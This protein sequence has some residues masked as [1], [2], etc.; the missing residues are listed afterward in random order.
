MTTVSLAVLRVSFLAAFRSHPLRAGTCLALLLSAVAPSLVAFAFAGADQLAVEGALGTATLAGPLLALF[1]GVAF[2]TGDRP[3]EG[4]EPLLRV[5]SSPWTVVLAATGGTALAGLLVLLL[6]T[7]A[8]VAALLGAGIHPTPAV[9]AVP[10]AAAGAHCLAAAGAGIAVGA[11]APRALAAILASVLAAL[12][13][14]AASVGLPLPGSAVLLLPRDAAFGGLPASA[15]AWSALSCL[16]GWGAAAAAAVA[17]I[18]G[19]DLAPRPGSS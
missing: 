17:L 2:A 1:A 18:R 9:V 5:P 19:K 12:P 3:A 4:L 7:V 8:A 15:A 16:L 6:C 14:A 13:V 11:A 10:L